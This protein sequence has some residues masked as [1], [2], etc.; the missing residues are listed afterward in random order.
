MRHRILYAFEA[1]ERET[2]P[3]KRR[4]WL[5]FVIVGAGPTGVELSGA[6]GEIANDALKDDFR[7]IRPEEARILL[8]DNSPRVLGPFPPELSE[9]AENSLIGLG[10]R[11]V[12]SVRV[13]GVDASGVTIQSARGTERIEARTVLWA[14]GVAA[15]SFGRVLGEKVGAELDRSGRIV[16]D[17]HCNI[18]GRPE[19]FVIGD[20]AHFRAGEG[21]ALP[22]VSPVAM[23]QGRYVADVIERRL[24]GKPVKPFKYFNKGNLAVI[25][26]ASA[27]ADFG[28]MQFHGLMAWLVWLFVH[29]MYLVGFQN[30]LIVFIRWAFNYVTYN[31]G[32]RLITGAPAVA[33]E[34]HED[35]SKEPERMK[36][37][38]AR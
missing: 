12:L 37:S 16:V 18:P 13:T 33:P 6:L 5:T 7:S 21:K 1:A 34:D 36:P 23:Q 38:V 22:G 8:L 31:R 11:S 27:V 3:A 35:P 32:A 4:A 20:V 2:D 24:A 25:G 19:L 15:S 28:R 10:V 9:H 14:A 30:R 17:E 26:R 29:L